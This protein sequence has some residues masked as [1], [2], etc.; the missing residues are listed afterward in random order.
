MDLS[1]V[2]VNWNTLDM[3]RD[4]LVSVFQETRNILFELIVVDNGSTDG[5]SEM[6]RQEFPNVRL[7]VNQENTGYSK[8]NNQGIELAAGRHVCLLNSDTRIIDNALGGMVCF[9]DMY[10]AVG[11]VTC[12]LVN[13]DGSPQFGS[14]LGETNLLY[15]LSVETGLHKRYPESRIWGKPFLSYMDHS[16]THEL[17]VCPSAAIVIRRE[18]F[19]KTGLLDENIFF[20]TIDWDYSLRMRKSGW[21][22]YFFPDAK[23]MHYG[24]RSKKPIKKMLLGKDHRSRFY[25]FRKHYGIL[26][27]NIYRMLIILSSSSKLIITIFSLLLRKIIVGPESI[28][29]HVRGRING[30]M[31]RLRICFS[32]LNFEDLENPNK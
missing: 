8:A 3:L 24:G 25:Y 14:A 21:K 12:Q 32:S 10:P 23:I 30:H 2:I 7:I 31:T 6:V 9:L 29:N 5:S 17:E 26:Q 16:R 15:M 13:P 1:V 20:G 18:V 28:N 22:L 4:C 19:E 27:M 11:A